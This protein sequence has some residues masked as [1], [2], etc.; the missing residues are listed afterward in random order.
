MV[1]DL[2][3][4]SKAAVHAM[5]SYRHGNSDPALAEEIAKEY[6]TIIAKAEEKNE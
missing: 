3:R 5:Q 1:D 2:L 4:I 6:E